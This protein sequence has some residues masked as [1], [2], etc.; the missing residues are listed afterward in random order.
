M[1]LEKKKQESVESAEGQT[2]SCHFWMFVR[3]AELLQGGSRVPGGGSKWGGKKK[4]RGDLG[5]IYDEF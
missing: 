4:Q 5:R 3:G 1:R 2:N